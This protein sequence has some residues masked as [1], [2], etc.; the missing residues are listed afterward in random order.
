MGRLSRSKKEEKAKVPSKKS[1]KKVKGYFILFVGDE[2]GILSCIEG[3]VVTRRLYSPSPTDNTTDTLVTLMNEYP[4]YPIKMLVDTLDQSYVKHTLPPVTPIGVKKIVQ[5]RLD[6][7]FSNEDIKGYISLGREKSGR[8]D[9]NFMLIALAYSENLRNWCDLLYDLPNRFVGI[10]LAPVESQTLIQRVKKDLFQ[11]KADASEGKKK[12]FKRK[13]KN[14]AVDPSTE[15][16]EWDILVTNNKTGGFRQVVMKDGKLIFTRMSQILDDSNVSV[17][18]GNIEQETKNTIEYLRRLSYNNNSRLNIIMIVGEEIKKALS[19]EAFSSNQTEI[20]TPYEAAKILNI[21]DSVLSGDRYSDI[22]LSIAFFSAKKE[23][24]QLDTSFIRKA[25]N[26]YKYIGL[27]KGASA[28]GTLALIGTCGYF[29]YSAFSYAA[30]T[31]ELENDV[32]EITTRLT[33]FE[34]D[35]QDFKEDPYVVDSLIKITDIISESSPEFFTL[36]PSLAKII[37]NNLTISKLE[38]VVGIKEDVMNNGARPVANDQNDDITTTDIVFEINAP[39][40]AKLNVS[41]IW[42]KKLEFLE[43]ELDNYKLL[44]GSVPELEATTDE[45]SINF[46][47]MKETPQDGQVLEVPLNITGPVKKDGGAL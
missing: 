28:L 10:Y 37:D 12:G 23:Q 30:E 43:T 25:E 32:S 21:E 46:E 7:D 4:T 22:L 15:S 17:L 27:L 29:L 1:G 11:G 34:G 39:L 2:G 6:R 9:W 18:A 16:S 35:A 13:K 20:L 44:Q 3:G 47:K 5:R 14:D 40:D 41:D 33:R 8:K 42:S 45:V 26:L 24:L 38:W 19:S 31:S 36:L